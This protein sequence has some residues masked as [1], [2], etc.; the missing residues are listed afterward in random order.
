MFVFDLY[1]KLYF[2]F[3]SIF[4]FKMIGLA[5]GPRPCELRCNIELAFA[6]YFYF[7]LICLLSV[8]SSCCLLFNKRKV[9][10]FE[11]PLKAL[12]HIS[13]SAWSQ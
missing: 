8:F 10:R 2:F 6:F 9:L 12:A 1:T 4:S 5:Q 11:G 7:T 13:S 3:L